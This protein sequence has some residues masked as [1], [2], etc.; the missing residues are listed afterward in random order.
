MASQWKAKRMNEH[1]KR[2][3]VVEGKLKSFPQAK[4][5][6]ERTKLIMLANSSLIEKHALNPAS[7]LLLPLPLLQVLSSQQ[8]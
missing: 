7:V 3:K 1:K 8:T 4:A 2:V 6:K 5:R